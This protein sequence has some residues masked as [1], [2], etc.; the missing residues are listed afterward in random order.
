MKKTIVLVVLSFAGWLTA[1]TAQGNSENPPEDEN[2]Q[3]TVEGCVSQLSGHNILVQPD[4]SNSY[5]LEATG[6]IDVTGYLGKQVKVSGR[7]SPTSPTSSHS[8]RETGGGPQVTIM[9]DSINVI[10]KR[11]V[12]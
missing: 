5:V 8:I 6:T 3:V 11:C 12:H 7:E 1:Q 10:S 4:S 2:R 9:V